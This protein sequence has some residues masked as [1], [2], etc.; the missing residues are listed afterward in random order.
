MIE[1]AKVSHLLLAVDEGKM[2][3]LDGQSLKNINLAGA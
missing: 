2:S 3:Q 1:L